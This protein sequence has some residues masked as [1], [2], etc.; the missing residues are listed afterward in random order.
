MLADQDDDMITL[1]TVSALA[2]SAPMSVPAPP[3]PPAGQA[4]V[5]WVMSPVLCRGQGDTVHAE[6]VVRAADPDRALGWGAAAGFRPLTLDFRIDP[7]G[8]PLSITRT[9]TG[10]VPFADDVVPAFAASR[11]AP[12]AARTRCTVTFTARHEPISTAPRADL[13][14][15]TLVP[16]ATPPRAVWD[17]IRPDGSTCTDPVPDVLLRAFPDIKALPDQPGYRSWTMVGYD[18]DRAGKP[19]KPHTIAASGA[20]GFD[21]AAVRAVARSRFERGARTGCFFPYWKAPAT[22]PAPVPPE[23]DSVRPADASCPKTHDYDRKPV[24]RYPESYNRRHIEGWA[25][26]AFDVASWGATGNIRM[27]AA[28]PTGDFGEAATAMIGNL[29]FK[30]SP[31]GYTGCIDRVIYRIHKPGDPVGAADAD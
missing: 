3:T 20:G 29:T 15:Y 31:R 10:F 5:S 11:F 12:G 19:V 28:E 16:G 17:R 23:E 30:P 8:R 6:R 22:L 9:V 1:V 14:A 21:A 2:V 13:I 18:L 4:L 26:I 7:S 24:L 27:L 25:I